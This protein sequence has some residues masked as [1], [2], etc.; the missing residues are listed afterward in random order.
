MTEIISKLIDKMLPE[1]PVARRFA[2]L[3]L[4]V[5]IATA[6]VTWYVSSKLIDY[7]REQCRA[8]VIRS[9]ALIQVQI[10]QAI[11]EAVSAARDEWRIWHEQQ[12][13]AAVANA[14]A[15]V[16]YETVI[17]EIPVVVERSDCKRL[18]PDALRLFNQAYFT[19]D[20]AGGL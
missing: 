10:N 20:D 15:Q 19:N 8:E 9:D 7:G 12:L 5:L 2:A 1:N 13:A 18:G 4:I 14:Q 11:T 3:S 6:F 16:R 17:Q